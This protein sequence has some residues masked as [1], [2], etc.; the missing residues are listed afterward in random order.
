MKWRKWLAILPL[1][2]IVVGT[3][4]S[5]IHNKRKIEEKDRIA[6]ENLRRSQTIYDLMWKGEKALQNYLS[7]K[8][9]RH[10]DRV[11][12][13]Y[14]KGIDVNEV[15]QEQ[16]RLLCFIVMLVNDSVITMPCSAKSKGRKSF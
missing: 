9:P 13:S 12:D 5:I 8:N 16:S 1:I 4:Q 11:I 7:D 14:L 6:M 15:Y 2:G 3:R 10:L